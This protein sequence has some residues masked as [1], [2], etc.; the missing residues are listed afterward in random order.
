MQQQQQQQQAV[1]SCTCIRTHTWVHA[2]CEAV[3]PQEGTQL[4]NLL[5]KALYEVDA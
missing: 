5:V 3:L 1:T 4:G 2:F